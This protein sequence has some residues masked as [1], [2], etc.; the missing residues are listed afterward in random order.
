MECGGTVKTSLEVGKWVQVWKGIYKGDLGYATSTKG[1]EVQLLLIPHLSQPRTFRGNPFHSCF[2]PT[3]F[4][5]GVIKQL[6]S[7]EPVCIQDKI[8]SF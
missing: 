7:I 2:E 1:G 4:N 6:Y 5:Y 8:Y 3:L